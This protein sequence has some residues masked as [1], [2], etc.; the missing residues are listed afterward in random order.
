MM[1]G[2]PPSGHRS[3]PHT[4]DVRI[5]AWAPSR[6]ECV[7]E[8][9]MGMV[10]MFT[11]RSG[12]PPTGSAE[13]R[14]DAG[15]DRDMLVAAL[16]EVIFRM[17]TDGRLPTDASVIALDD[18][19]LQVRTRVAPTNLLRLIGAVPKAVSWHDLVFAA[20][21]NGWSCGVTLDV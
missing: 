14:V 15:S 6:E 10:Q 1:T 16:D 7:A 20:D 21:E 17:D 5:E 4:A 8:A 11:D 19:G 13:F 9:I 3:V 12:V 18:G 2:R